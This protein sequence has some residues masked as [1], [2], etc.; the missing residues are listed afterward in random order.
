MSQK[1]DLHIGVHYCSVSFKDGV[2]LKNRI[3]RRAKHIAKP[4]DVITKDGT[5]IKGA[6]YPSDRSLESLLVL[7][8]KNL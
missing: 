4:Y 1:K 8:T 7:V 6:I 2:Q 5:S 3:K